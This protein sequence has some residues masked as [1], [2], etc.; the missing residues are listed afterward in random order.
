M[1]NHQI[2]SVVYEI[3]AQQNAPGR[4]T[5][6]AEVCDQLGIGPG[7]RVRVSVEA[8]GITHQTVTKTLKGDREASSSTQGSERVLD[9]LP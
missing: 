9:R 4:F 8:G 1:S 5:V 3:D 2:V 6:P 7:S